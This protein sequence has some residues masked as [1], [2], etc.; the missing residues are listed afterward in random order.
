MLQE[1]FAG[2]ANQVFLA[3][4][5]IGRTRAAGSAGCNDK[6]LHGLILIT[7]IVK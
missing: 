1:Q 5:E 4:F 6:C 7:Q 2:D 3:G